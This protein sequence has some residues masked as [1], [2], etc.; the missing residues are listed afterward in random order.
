MEVRAVRR[1]FPALGWP[2]AGAGGGGGAADG[3]VEPERDLAETAAL[4]QQARR[5]CSRCC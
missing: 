4:L 1:V 5:A 3:N 2:A